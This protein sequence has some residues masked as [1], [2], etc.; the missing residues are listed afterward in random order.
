MS[1]PLTTVVDALIEF[2]LSLLRD[3]DALAEFEADPVETLSRKGLGDVCAEDVRAVAPVVVDRPDVVPKAPVVPTPPTPPGPPDPV[4]EIS[5]IVNTF[6]TVDN[7]ATII[8]QSVNQNIWAEGDVT[9]VFDQS[10][11]V[12]SGDG[13]AAAGDDA[14]VDSSDTDITVGDVSIGNTDTTTTTTDS[15]NDN[16]TTTDTTTDADVDDSF[17]DDSTTID[18]A[19][20]DS[21][22]DTSST[23]DPDADAGFPAPDASEA[24]PVAEDDFAPDA[25]SIEA[26]AAPVESAFDEP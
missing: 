11:I 20:V 3:P 5:R 2:I 10:A 19:V 8:D 12:A 23:P 9:Q 14:V 1:T 18:T 16:S 21:F 4:T 17:N 13:A 25:T 24:D 7:R 6:V 15:N 26:D 22:N